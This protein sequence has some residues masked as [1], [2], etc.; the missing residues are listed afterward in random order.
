MSV[1]RARK[2]R[3]ESTD[4]ERRMWFLLRHKQFEGYKF[5]RQEPIGTYIVDIVWFRPRLIIEIDGGQH[6][7]PHQSEQDQRRTA[8]LEGEGFRVLRFW[9]NDVLQ[10]SEGVL[11]A[12]AAALSDL[13]QQ[14]ITFDQP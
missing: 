10:N 6:N 2:L 5:R 4:A 13:A 12:I 3:R 7:M 8:W 11:E 9:N 14:K 1:P